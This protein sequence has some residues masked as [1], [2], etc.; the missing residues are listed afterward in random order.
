[1]IEHQY[2]L[3]V[4]LLLIDLRIGR[5]A[6]TQWRS[7]TFSHGRA[8]YYFEIISRAVRYL[9]NLVVPRYWNK[10]IRASSK[11]QRNDIIDFSI[12]VA[13]P[14]PE[15]LF[16]AKILAIATLLKIIACYLLSQINGKHRNIV[17]EQSIHG[18]L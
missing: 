14:S 1:M 18:L 6:Y 5:H 15:T 10:T 3:I 8:H 9:G 16:E 4:M 13:L 12:I 11:F 7:Q 17:I 2:L